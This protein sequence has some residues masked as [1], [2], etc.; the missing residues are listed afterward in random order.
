MEAG[1]VKK[2]SRKK[3]KSYQIPFKI[4]IN[5][6]LTIQIQIQ[7]KATKKAQ[8]QNPSKMSVEQKRAEDKG[9]MKTLTE[10]RLVIRV[11]KPTL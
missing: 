11:R 2:K 6:K 9:S 7:L 1:L 5:N 4:L 3:G 8:L 10:G